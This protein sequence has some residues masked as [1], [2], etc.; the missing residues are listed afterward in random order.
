MP[1][2]LPSSDPDPLY[3][4]PSVWLVAFHKFVMLLTKTVTLCLRA[5]TVMFKAGC[6]SWAQCTIHWA[7][8]RQE[9]RRA[10]LDARRQPQKLLPPHEMKGGSK[11]A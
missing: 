10:Q 1:L 5:G 11:R 8:S 6:D 2:D 7:H 9:I 4:V 3:L